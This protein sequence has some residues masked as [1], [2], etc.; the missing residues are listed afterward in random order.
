MKLEDYV[1]K[2]IENRAEFL[3]SYKD[4]FDSLDPEKN[5]RKRAEIIVELL[6]LE[7]D[8]LKETWIQ[9]EVIKWHRTDCQDYID[10]AF[11][12]PTKKQRFT[13]IRDAMVYR[14]VERIRKQGLSIWKACEELAEKLYN[15]KQTT[16][17]FRKVANPDYDLP[18][19][20]KNAY[21][22]HKARLKSDIPRP[23]YGSDISV[24]SHDR[25]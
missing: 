22:R 4:K 6:Q 2:S 19:A 9:A 17:F 16:L 12:I 24:K 8:H 5:R 14:R 25:R 13:P 21:N 15:Q 11:R 10:K 20:I 23:Y 7:I 18:I 3:K 1:N